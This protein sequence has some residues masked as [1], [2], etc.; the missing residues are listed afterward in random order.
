MIDWSLTRSVIATIAILLAIP[1]LN[2]QSSTIPF[3]TLIVGIITLLSTLILEMSK[4]R[5][6]IEI[7]FRKIIYGDKDHSSCLQFQ[8][9][10]RNISSRPTAIVDIYKK[11]KNGGLLE[12]AIKDVELP[13]R[14]DAW[15]VKIVRFLMEYEEE[16]RIDA[17]VI[18]DMD[19]YKFSVNAET[20]QR[21]KIKSFW[22]K[23]KERIWHR[24]KKVK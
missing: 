12:G 18:Q 17:I 10:L 14:L 15:D 8:L 11:H 19:G 16:P 6:K 9:I 21:R 4:R 24:L 5:A 13:I 3:I 22:E 2:L 20:G 23:P 7:W 1:F